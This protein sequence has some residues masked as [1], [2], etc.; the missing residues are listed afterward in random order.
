MSSAVP[1][2]KVAVGALTGAMVTLVTL[3]LNTY[4]LPTNKQVP[5]EL[6]AAATTVLTFVASYM[7]PDKWEET[8][9]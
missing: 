4:V 9:M 3:T 1:K 6:A 5:P 7:T 8:D 2:R